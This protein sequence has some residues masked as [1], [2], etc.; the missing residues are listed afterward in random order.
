MT[1]SNAF[2]DYYSND[3]AVLKKYGYL[4]IKKFIIKD[5]NPL[6]KYLDIVRKYEP[7]YMPPQ[8]KIRVVDV[9]WLQRSMAHMIV[10]KY[11]H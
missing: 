6:Q 7:S 1:I 3:D 10:Q 9:M 8:N 11:G 4:Y 2:V 5:T